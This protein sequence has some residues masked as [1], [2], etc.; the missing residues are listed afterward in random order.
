LNSDEFSAADGNFEALRG[1]VPRG[2]GAHWDRVD[3]PHLNATKHPLCSQFLTPPAIE[4]VE[5]LVELMSGRFLRYPLFDIRHLS[6]YSPFSIRH[7]LR[8][9]RR[10]QL[11]LPTSTFRLELRLPFLPGLR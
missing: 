6:C 9:S 4:A 2:A 11:Q 8:R 10:L 1:N 5:R 7:S 3:V